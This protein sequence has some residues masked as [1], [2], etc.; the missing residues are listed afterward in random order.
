MNPP[1][2]SRR[3]GDKSLLWQ[4]A[5]S[6]KGPGPAPRPRKRRQGRAGDEELPNRALAATASFYRTLH[7]EEEAIG[8]PGKTTV[9][10][11][12]RE[13]ARQ[14]KQREKDARR[15]QRKA[16]KES[17]APRADGE[18]PDLEGLHWGPQPP[19]F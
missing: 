15:A 3:F 10:K 13:K 16:E 2:R 6:A 18:D 14:Q 17:R 4:A 12:D 7:K 19:L 11:R 9:A 8:R 5:D 1:Q